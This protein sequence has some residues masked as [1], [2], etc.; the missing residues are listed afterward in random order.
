MNT[1]NYQKHFKVIT[2]G[3]GLYLNRQWFLQVTQDACSHILNACH[4]I[5]I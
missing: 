4:K 2:I 1:T 3:K 5:I